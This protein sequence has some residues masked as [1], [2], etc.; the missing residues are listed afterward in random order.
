[1][2][3]RDLGRKASQPYRTKVPQDW[4]GNFIE[5]AHEEALYAYGEY[6]LFTLMWHI[7]DYDA[8]LVGHCQTCYNTTSSRQAEAF[9]QP[10]QRR[11]PDC[12]GTT[13]EG[14]FRA[15]I[16]RPALLT[17]RD[18]EID[19]TQQG[20]VATDTITLET[21]S[22]FTFH[23]GDYIFR[24]D[25][26]RFQAEEKNEAIVRTGFSPPWAPNSFAGATT[27]HLEMA[28]AVAYLI[29][30][31]DPNVL[32]ALLGTRGGQ[33]VPDLDAYTTLRP[34]GYLVAPGDSPAPMTGPSYG[35]ILTGHGAPPAS[36]L[37][38]AGTDYLDLD[39]GDLYQSGGM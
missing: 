5:N 23:L 2:A 26:T 21:T 27:A 34:N 22:D 9:N 37:M 19:E 39:T 11:C 10:T 6:C 32:A 38:P 13:F 35:D 30:P 4:E 36:L 18:Q 25:N 31:T 15:Q 28:T 8:G 14:G 3:E 16:I 17:D 1:M 7:E 20:V 24:F 33:T 12:F 29:P